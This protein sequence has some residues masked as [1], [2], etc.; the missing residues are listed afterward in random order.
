MRKKNHTFEP[1]QASKLHR[2]FS[3]VRVQLSLKAN[4]ATPSKTPEPP[5]SQASEPDYFTEA[6]SWA[7]DMYTHAVV[8][9]NRYKMAFFI[10]M[11][12]AVLLT[13]AINGLIPMQH[14]E[15]LLIHHYQDGRVTVLP[16]TQ[17]YAPMNQAQVESEI[18]R[19]VINRE[20]YNPSSYHEQYALINLMSNHET[21]MEYINQ[22]AAGNKTAPINVLGNQGWRSVHIDSVVFLD[23]TLQNRHQPK[24]KQ[25]HHNL[26]EVNFTLTDHFKNSALRKTK[27]LTALVAWEYRGTPSDPNDRWRNW[28][29][30]TMTR[31][32]LEQRNVTGD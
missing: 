22:Q 21:G 6:R 11:G 4:P 13:V 24:A 26:A 16:M 25:T 8:S 20:S 17:P 7:D 2:F 10:A 3:W 9:R 18:V 28:N 5:L 12:L 29:G 1:K 19:Y 14:L 30:F 15:P 32:T 31:Y 27:A 23:S